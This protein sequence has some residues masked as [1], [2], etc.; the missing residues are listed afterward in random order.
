MTSEPMDEA[1][2]W[3]VNPDGLAKLLQV[4]ERPLEGDRN[5]KN[6]IEYADF[7][8]GMNGTL[9]RALDDQHVRINQLKAET[10]LLKKQIAERKPKGGRPPIDADKLARIEAELASGHSKRS[11]ADRHRVSAMT[12]VR[13]AKRIADRNAIANE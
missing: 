11:I 2:K 10:T 7:L 12:V 13:I 6:W 8:L 9:R 4:G 5:V 3:N 1:R